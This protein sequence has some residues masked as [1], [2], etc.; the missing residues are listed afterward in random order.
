MLSAVKRMQLSA[1]DVCLVCADTWLGDVNMIRC[2]RVGV[3]VCVRAYT[4]IHIHARDCV[5]CL[6]THR[7]FMARRWE[8]LKRSTTAFWIQTLMIVPM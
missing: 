4:P 2:V 8:E 3:G 5:C 6:Q 1:D 7:R